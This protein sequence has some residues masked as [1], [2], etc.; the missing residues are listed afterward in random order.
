MCI[1]D[2]GHTGSIFLKKLT[3]INIFLKNID[4]YNIETI[5]MCLEILALI[6]SRFS[7]QNKNF[8]KDISLNLFLDAIFST[9]SLNQLS[10][11]SIG[12]AYRFLY[13]LSKLDLKCH[14]VI[15]DHKIIPYLTIKNEKDHITYVQWQI[16]LY[17]NIISDHQQQSD[18]NPLV[19]LRKIAYYLQPVII[20]HFTSDLLPKYK[21]YYKKLISLLSW[22]SGYVPLKWEPIYT[23]KLN[24]II[25]NQDVKSVLL[26][27]LRNMYDPEV[28]I[29]TKFAE[30]IP[31]Q[32][33]ERLELKRKIFQMPEQR[34]IINTLDDIQKLN[35]QDLNYDIIIQMTK[36]FKKNIYKNDKSLNF[37]RIK[38]FIQTLIQNFVEFA[39]LE[40]KLALID[41]NEN[42]SFSLYVNNNRR[43][44][45]LTLD[46]G[47]I[48]IDQLLSKNKISFEK[49]EEKFKEKKLDSIAKFPSLSLIHI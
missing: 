29:N 35:Q 1:R 33:N 3:S 46:C 26:P 42:I 7:T 44:F 5:E 14:Q 41:L 19:G 47:A 10:E 9:G 25:E 32:P 40:S 2:S 28:I 27:L 49:L 38:T 23:Q 45:P 22:V 17:F 36:F 24:S 8:Y 20:R 18:P 4:S 37:D 39:K 43:R 21:P 31:V 13:Y 34:K 11:A 15:I 12:Y 6:A 48:I 16:D 30:N